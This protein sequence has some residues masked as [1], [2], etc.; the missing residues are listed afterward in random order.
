M[1]NSHKYIYQGRASRHDQ[2]SRQEQKWLNWFGGEDL[3]VSSTVSLLGWNFIVSF[4]SLL[5]FQTNGN[6][7]P[8]V[9]IIFLIANIRW[10]WRLTRLAFSFLID[11]LIQEFLEMMLAQASSGLN[12]EKLDI[13][14]IFKVM[15]K[16]FF[17]RPFIFFNITLFLFGGLSLIVLFRCSTR[18]AT[19]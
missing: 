10:S 8:Y 16:L 4:L 13:E 14:D 11:W 1:Q 17:F 7:S 2:Q 9:S 18:M 19:E 15:K 6:N 12:N 5:W 3:N